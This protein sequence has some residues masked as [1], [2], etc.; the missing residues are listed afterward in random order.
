M[1]YEN[2]LSCLVEGMKAISTNGSYEPDDH[3]SRVGRGY[4]DPL[5]ESLNIYLALKSYQQHFNLWSVTTLVSLVAIK[6]TS[7]RI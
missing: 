3:E 6:L 7:Q 1:L 2:A 5:R 4:L